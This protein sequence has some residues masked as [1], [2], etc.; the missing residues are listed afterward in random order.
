MSRVARRLAAALVVV[1]VAILA[2]R[3]G[4]AVRANG[5]DRRAI[6]LG[7]DGLDPRMLER[8]MSAGQLPNFTRL[9]RMGDRRDLETSMPPLSPVAWSNFITGQ[10]AGGHGI[11][12]FVHRDP[13]TMTP[14]D[15]IYR[16][17]APRWTL[18]FGVWQFPLRSGHVELLRRGQPFWALL[19][20]AGVETTMF[21]VPVNFPPVE[22]GGH[23]LSGMGTPDVAGTHGTFSYFSDD[24]AEDGP[25]PGGTR[26]TVAVHDDHVRATLTGPPNP[27]RSDGRELALDFDVYVDPVEPAARIDIGGR[28]LVLKAGEWSDWVPVTFHP[29]PHLGGINAAVRLYLKSVRPRFGLYVT[30]L[31]IDP[32]DPALTISTPADWSKDLA[33]RLGR[34]YTQELPEDTKALSS[35]VFTGREFWDQAQFVYREARSAFDDLLGRFDRGLLFFYIGSVDQTSHMLYRNM[36]PAHPNFQTDAVLSSAVQTVYREMD[37]MLGRVLD[38]TD[39]RTTVIVLSDHGFAPFYWGVN[40]NTWLLDRGYVTLLS[41]AQ[42]D[43]VSM[44]ANVDW[45]RTTA[46]AV[47]LNGLY[48]NLAGR[49]RQ[50]I[51]D[52]A[53]YDA[54]LD[55][56]ERDLIAMRDPATG[57]RPISLVYRTRRELHGPEASHAPDIIV[58][59][60]RGYRTSWQSPLGGFPSE[61]FVANRDPWSGD[62]AVDYRLVP[63]V[64]M[65]NRRMAVDHPRLVDVTV[66]I[67]RQFGVDP[68]TDMIGRDVFSPPSHDERTQ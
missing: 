51:V 15:A 52:P 64:L 2:A 14:Y 9:A 43:G 58:G 5:S 36:D 65:A 27:Y 55:R 40:L 21:R 53:E 8:F 39:D 45:R 3:C 29:V 41:G 50:G 22:S 16:T 7:I 67:L 25:V 37:D 34:F 38:R 62:H 59:Y 35:G 26:R 61:V 48:L 13:E 17:V 33:G 56:L 11:F 12:D 4:T 46:Y 32:A 47:G 44:F 63:G 19:Q 20:D 6:V 10:D 18:P 57:L 23:A 1:L 31:Q 54:L 42:R 66:S 68:G 60:S 28:A 24:A 30:P 49:E